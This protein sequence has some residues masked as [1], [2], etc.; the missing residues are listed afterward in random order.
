MFLMSA[1]VVY[2]YHAVIDFFFGGGG[3]GVKWSLCNLF[4]L[5][6]AQCKTNKISVPVVIFTRLFHLHCLDELD[7]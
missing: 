3:G 4:L 7:V 1:V 5:N 2:L 6:T